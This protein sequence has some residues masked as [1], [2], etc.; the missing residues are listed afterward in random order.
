M[1]V[2]KV[3]YNIGIKSSI[4]LHR[5]NKK[6]N[7]AKKNQ[8]WDEWSLVSNFIWSLSKLQFE[9]AKHILLLQK[10]I[11]PNHCQRKREEKKKAQPKK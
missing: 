1:F 7:D 9:N 4:E 8:F 11:N 3:S 5:K 6:E 10:K 2:S